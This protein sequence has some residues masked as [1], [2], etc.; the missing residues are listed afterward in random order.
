MKSLIIL[1][2]LVYG[3]SDGRSTEKGDWKILNILKLGVRPKQKDIVK[4]FYFNECFRGKGML[5]V[6]RRDTIFKT[7]VYGFKNEM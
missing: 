7:F 5:I 4:I 6:F 1:F 2:G 3:V